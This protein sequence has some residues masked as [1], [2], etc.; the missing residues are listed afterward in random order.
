M[1]YR[2]IILVRSLTLVGAICAVGS[3]SFADTFDW[4]A[5]GRK[6]FAAWQCTSLAIISETNTEEAER[7]F[8]LGYALMA[9]LLHGIQ[10]GDVSESEINRLP[11][12]ITMNIGGGPSVD[13]IAGVVW[14][15]N[16]SALYDELMPDIEGA[17]FDDK[18]ELQKYK[19]ETRFRNENC[20]LIR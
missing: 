14:A 2:A 20:E 9:E 16:F 13:F 4:G 19:A 18:K 1:A 11:I 15:N 17:P 8:P 5:R 6:A 7:L 10:G 3:M 12:G